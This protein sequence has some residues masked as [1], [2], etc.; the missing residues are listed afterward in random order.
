MEQGQIALVPE[1]KSGEETVR[2]ENKIVRM[3][4]MGFFFCLNDSAI[5]ID[6]QSLYTCNKCQTPHY[7]EISKTDFHIC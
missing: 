7:H 1:A 5:N 3:Q 2:R 4:L 6:Y